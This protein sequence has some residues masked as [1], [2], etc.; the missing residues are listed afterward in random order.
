M[1]RAARIYLRSRRSHTRTY[2]RRSLLTKSYA[3]GPREVGPRENAVYLTTSD[4][5]QP[6]LLEQTVGDHF[7]SVVASHGDRTA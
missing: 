7:R 3:R 2:C 4:L 1:R 6:P 5:L